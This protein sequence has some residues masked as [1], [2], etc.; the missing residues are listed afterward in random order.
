MNELRQSLELR[1]A[2]M[3]RIRAF[4]H[5]RDFLEVET[6]IR[7]RAPCMELHVDAE[8]S[9]GAFLRTSPELS[10]KKL[11]AGGAQR[12]FELAKC[13]RRG[14]RGPLHHPEYLMLEWYRAEADYD[15]VLEDVRDLLAAVWPE[16]RIGWTVLSVAEAFARHAGWNPIE[17]YDADR[18]DVDMAERVE[19][20]L[21]EIGGAVVLKDY[22]AE[23]AALARLKP[24]NPRLA[25][26]WELY[27]DGVELANAYSELTDP[28]E[29][30]R[31]FETCARQRAALGKP[32]YPIDETFLVALGR[33]PAAGG[34][35]LGVDRLLMLL[36][37]ADSLDAVLPFREP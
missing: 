25:E 32:V 19:P 35:A 17:S 1:D 27:L 14:E 16:R 23:A 12:I 26:R 30:R 20:A 3:R 7:L 18:F 15:D 2:A 28:D 29:Q 31:R 11:L 22:P 6:P 5:A 4:F 21:R 36:A 33:M 24:E 13:F 37:G 10:H 8:P 9:G 34:A